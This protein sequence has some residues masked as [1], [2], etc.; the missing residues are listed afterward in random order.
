MKYYRQAPLRHVGDVPAMGAERYGEKRALE[1]RGQEYSYADLDR[2]AHRGGVG[3]VG[4][5]GGAGGPVG[6]DVCNLLEDPGQVSGIVLA[7]GRGTSPAPP[8]G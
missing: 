6:A 1:Y 8:L 3:P 7:G 2:R 4:L 5:G